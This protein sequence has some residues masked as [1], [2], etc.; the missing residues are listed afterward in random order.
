MRSLIFALVA[1]MMV[2]LGTGFPYV[3][4]FVAFWILLEILFYREEGKR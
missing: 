4:V 3:L 2:Y 1:G